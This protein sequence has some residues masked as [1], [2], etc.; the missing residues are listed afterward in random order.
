MQKLLFALLLI[1][2]GGKSI[3][4]TPCKLRISG[5][6]VDNHDGLALQFASVA[7]SGR[8]IGAVT[9]D[10]GNFVLN[11]LCPGQYV[12]QVSHIGCE[13]LWKNIELT[14][15][16]TLSLFLEHHLFELE[17]L[18]ITASKMDMKQE[19]YSN[20]MDKKVSMSIGELLTEIPGITTISSGNTIQKPVVRGLHSDRLLI[21]N[22][23]V[24]Q[25]SQQW[26]LDHAPEID[27]FFSGKTKVYKD[28]Q[29]LKYG[30]GAIGG[31][32]VVDPAQFRNSIGTDGQLG[33]SFNSNG[34]SASVGVFINHRFKKMDNITYQLGLST[35]KSG[36][37]KTPN[38]FL[39]NTGQ[40]M[41][42]FT[43]RI[44]YSSKIFS[45]DARYVMINQNLGVFSGAHIGNLTDLERAISNDSSNY[46]TPFSY[47]I[48]SPVQKINNEIFSIEARITTNHNPIK[49]NVARQFDRRREFDKERK[50]EDGP[51]LQ[52]DLLTYSSQISYPT[53][54]WSNLIELEIGASL[55]QSKNT[56][57]GVFFIPNYDQVNSGG[58]L[59]LTHRSPKSK[60]SSTV[61]LDQNNRTVYIY[62]QNKLNLYRDTYDGLSV[63][64]S[65]TRYLTKILKSEIGLTS[66][67]RAPS[68]NELFSNGVHHGS[69]QVEK[70]NR[71]LTKEKAISVDFETTVNYSNISFAISPFINYFPNYIYLQPVKPA[72]LTIRGAFPT[73]EYRQAEVL[74]RGFELEANYT[75]NSQFSGNSNFSIV[76]ANI[77]ESGDNLPLIPPDN[78]G[79]S[80][81]YSTVSEDPLEITIKG[82]YTLKQN[83][84]VGIDD[85]STPPQS[86]FLIGLNAS[87][88]V[89]LNGIEFNFL[90]GADN[91][92]NVQYRNYLN[93]YRYFADDLGRSIYVKLKIN[94]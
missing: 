30:A 71:E 38:Y 32:L 36:N 73:F 76:R 64:I 77:S 54:L 53:S 74:F 89:N 45:L 31:V 79:Q 72:T 75:L 57:D 29:K 27:P 6:I 68:V 25:K 9:N 55:S 2:V 43:W 13:P 20:I 61:R 59:F 94:F 42:N 85:Y 92:M 86:Y 58:F 7:I 12:I 50:I 16:T 17:I 80:F 23:G 34:N 69:A 83:R 70:G 67:Y 47:E 11:E 14:S 37:L 60:I 18:N 28:A 41:L 33:T 5:K 65:Y 10:Q 40:E 49:I 78:I 48:G 39:D 4:Q 87:K 66:T 3:A 26:G 22:G 90:V 82:N 91:I 19:Y 1:I 8:A 81:T 15:D 93:R 51:A 35:A 84:T 44:G 21:Q 63:G 62:E 56:Y 52:L 88:E 46:S 24:S